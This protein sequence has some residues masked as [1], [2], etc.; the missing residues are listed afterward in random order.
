MS[1]IDADIAS[2]VLNTIGIGSASSKEDTSKEEYDGNILDDILNT[3]DEKF[4]DDD[5]MKGADSVLDDI[6]DDDGASLEDHDVEKK[7]TL[8]SDISSN[9][10]EDSGDEHSDISASEK[11]SDSEDNE[12][13]DE[14]DS[15]KR[16]KFKKE[17]SSSGHSDQ[18]DNETAS[19]E[20]KKKGKKYDYATKLNYLFRDA[21]FFLVKSNNAEN[22]AL[23]KAKSVWSTPPQ[24]E[25]KFNQAFSESRN[26]ILIYSV[27]E[28]GKFCG[29]ARLATESR[30]DGARVSWV[31]PPGLSA[32]ALGGVFKI[33]WVCRGDLSFNKVQHLYNPWNEGK[34]VKIGRDGQEIEPKVGEELGR[35]FLEDKGVDLTPILRKSKEAAR[36]HRAK[37]GNVKSGPLGGQHKVVRPGG[38]RPRGRGGDR[39]RQPRYQGDRGGHSGYQEDRRY[40]RERDRSGERY[41]DSRDYAEYLRCLASGPSHYSAHYLPPPPRYYDAPS[42]YYDRSV[43]THDER[44]RSYD[45]SVDEFLRR[46][47]GFD[48]ERE[49]DRERRSRRY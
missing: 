45:R 34:P 10:G 33:D 19:G 15:A 4:E 41:R 14:P 32:R 22:V 16:N 35:L 27:K 37:S 25:S 23:A 47:A 48:R 46:T 31:L 29:L 21:R 43:Y 18:G 28:S 1:G 6:D 44:S 40:F 2:G 42:S 12:D 5:L 26:V 39:R 3:G 36:K 20:K 7:D 9:G 17:Q 13:A 8:G 49:R 24:N 30:R 38:Q 11:N